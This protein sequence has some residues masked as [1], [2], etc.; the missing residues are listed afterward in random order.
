MRPHRG[1]VTVSVKLKRPS[2][3]SRWVTS[4]TPGVAGTFVGSTAGLTLIAK[5]G[6]STPAGG[7]YHM[8]AARPDVSINNNGDLLLR[9]DI[10]GGTTNSAIFIRRGP[11]GPLQAVVTQ[12]QGAPGTE[13]AF[14]TIPSGI[15][16]LFEE[17]IQLDNGGNVAFQNFYNDGTIRSFANWR[18][19]PDNTIEEILVRGTVR[20]E[21]GGG[22][23]VTSAASISWNSGS[24]YPIWARVTGGNFREGIFLSVPKICN[25]TPEG[26][27][28]P[29][30][31]VDSTTGEAPLTMTF[32][33]VD[34]PGETTLT[35]SAAGP[36]M[37]SWTIGPI[38]VT[39]KVTVSPCLTV[40][41]SGTNRSC[42]MATM[43]IT[44]GEGIDAALAAPVY[45]RD[46]VAMTTLE[47]RLRKR[48]PS[49]TSARPGPDG[50]A[51]RS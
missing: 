45:L 14:E 31:V 7:T 4:T 12:G 38:V 26:N 49:A 43:P 19:K 46:K 11:A 23:A 3:S 34:T 13:G 25:T 32:D 27:D 8:P 51:T 22:A 30:T 6:D 10:T 24:R 41:A 15:N 28:V 44:R 47:R 1:C 42:G 35:T 9:S 21:F 5:H 50:P 36:T 40:M 20:P 29:V 16:G 37:N 18:I 17:S 2:R 39:T 48:L 33:N